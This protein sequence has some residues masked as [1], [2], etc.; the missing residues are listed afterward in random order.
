MFVCPPKMHVL[1]IYTCSFFLPL[2]IIDKCACVL[3]T[4]ASSSSL[5]HLMM[6]DNLKNEALEILLCGPSFQKKIL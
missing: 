4:Q 2:Q 6:E 5:K 3:F 1:I